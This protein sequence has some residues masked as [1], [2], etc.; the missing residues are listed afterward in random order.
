MKLKTIGKV[1]CSFLL[2]L[3]FTYAQLFKPQQEVVDLHINLRCYGFQSEC[4]S[5]DNY[6]YEY[7]S[8]IKKAQLKKDGDQAIFNFYENELAKAK[9]VNKVVLL[10]F[11]QVYD[12]NGNTLKDKSEYYTPN[13]FIHMHTKGSTSLLFGASV[14]PYR[15]DLFNTIDQY[16][17]HANLFYLNPSKQ[18]FDLNSAQVE[19]LAKKLSVAGVPLMID[20]SDPTNYNIER[21]LKTG[22]TTILSGKWMKGDGTSLDKF[23]YL[24]SLHKTYSNLFASIDSLPLF[25]TWI[26]YFSMVIFTEDWEG[27]LVYGSGH[28]F[29]HPKL[30]SSWLYPKL[31]GTPFVEA[32]NHVK[33][34][35]LDYALLFK[36][37]SDTR[38]ET[39]Y[40]S[41]EIIRKK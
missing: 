19:L 33:D 18:H 36:R 24:T 40:R 30:Y 16:A 17:P 15:A 11:D 9:W 3:N 26:D 34:N 25:G 10:A 38:Y 41:G 39:L 35:R 1:G 21:I 28:P 32:L 8:P 22:V 23:K 31:W 7:F 27:K 29:D 4:Y 5:K 13:R 37:A 12:K 6:W 20:L 2:F 14:H